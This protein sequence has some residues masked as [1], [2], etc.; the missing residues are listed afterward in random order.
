MF[1][2]RQSKKKSDILNSLTGFIKYNNG[3]VFAFVALFLLTGVVFAASPQAREAIISSEEKIVSV[4]NS[5]LLSVDLDNFGLCERG[6]LE[7]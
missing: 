2:E 4:D 3:F 5:L 1:N 6:R 7:F